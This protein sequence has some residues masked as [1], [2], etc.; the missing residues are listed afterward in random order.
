MRPFSNYLFPGLHDQPSS[1]FV[2]QVKIEEVQDKGKGINDEV[3]KRKD[4]EK[5]FAR[6]QH[7]N[8]VFHRQF[9]H[10]IFPGF[11]YE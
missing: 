10:D 4:Y 9:P 5:Y 2:F 1:A 6:P 7:Q 11:P 3:I 8:R